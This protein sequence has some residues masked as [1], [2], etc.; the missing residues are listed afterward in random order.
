MNTKSLMK[1]S[2]F[3]LF[4]FIS[5]LTYRLYFQTP[6]GLKLDEKARLREY[7]I[8]PLP[9]KEVSQVQ[10]YVN[11][12]M[13]FQPP[14]AAEPAV[15]KEQRQRIL[16]MA[17]SDLMGEVLAGRLVIA[18]ECKKFDGALADKSFVEMIYAN[19]GRQ[20]SENQKAHDDCATGLFF[21]KSIL[22]SQ[23]NK[24]KDLRDLNTQSLVHELFADLGLANFKTPAAVERMKQITDRLVELMPDSPG[25]YKAAVIPQMIQAM[26]AIKSGQQPGESLY[27]AIERALAMSPGDEQIENVRNLMQTREGMEISL[28]KASA[29]AASEPDSVSTQ[30]FYAKALA[31]HK[32]YEGSK[33]YIDQLAARFPN[34]PRIVEAQKRLAKNP[35]DFGV[36]EMSLGSEDL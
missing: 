1:F 11:H 36:F 28:D 2:I 14:G 5:L 15:C 35:A 31:R 10:K 17:S 29:L 8:A 21:Y 9:K 27:E 3:G 12:Q 30:I 32:D 34:D 22:V 4:V 13:K 20:A 26:D 19:C 33:A 18:A 24:G 23:S 6:K 7:V 25:A 16:S